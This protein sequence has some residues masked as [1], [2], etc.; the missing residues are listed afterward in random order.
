M[1]AW[2][3]LAEGEPGAG[4]V[5]RAARADPVAEVALGRGAEARR[6][7]RP[8]RSAAMSS[9]VRWVAW[10]SVLSGVRCPASAK[11]LRRGHAVRRQALLVLR[12]LLGE[13]DV[14]RRRPCARLIWSSGT[15][16]TE[17]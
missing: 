17:W 3:S 5:Q 15:A 7:C 8:R 16:R 14:Q 12:D 9:S 11:H 1:T 6:R 10:T 2:L 4:V 13:V